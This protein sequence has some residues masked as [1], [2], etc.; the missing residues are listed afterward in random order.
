MP[1]AKV[2]L[3][4]A[5]ETLKNFDWSK[6]DAL[7]DD[8]IAHQIET[9]SDVAPDMSAALERHRTQID[10]NRVDMAA[11]RNRL[12]MTQAEFARAYR[13]SLGSVRDIEQGRRKP[14]G[15][16]AALLQLIADNPDYVRERLRGAA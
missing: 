11:L 1:I 2:T 8:D 3:S 16:V 6:I 4:Q 14:S 13:F 10:R 5:L 7:T 9:D 15:P 12:G